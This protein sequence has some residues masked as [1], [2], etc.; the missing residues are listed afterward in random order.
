MLDFRTEAVSERPMANSDPIEDAASMAEPRSIMI[1]TRYGTYE[2][3]RDKIVS[4][5]KGLIVW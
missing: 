3:E 5:P 2:V 1:E 4:F